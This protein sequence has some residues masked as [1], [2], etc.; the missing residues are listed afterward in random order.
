MNAQYENL[1]LST[2]RS[3]YDKKI[4]KLNSRLIN[5]ADWDDV[6]D[7][8]ADV[9]ELSIAIGYKSPGSVMNP[10][11]HSPGEIENRVH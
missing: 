8:R 11:E 6:A 5:G 2:L 9:T 1:D 3:M 10:A 7:L 4:Q